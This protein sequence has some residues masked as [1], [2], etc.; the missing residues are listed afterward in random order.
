MGI[1]KVIAFTRKLLTKKISKTKNGWSRNG[2]NKIERSL[3]HKEM[4]HTNCLSMGDCVLFVYLLAYSQMN[5][6]RWMYVRCTRN[7]SKVNTRTFAGRSLRHCRYFIWLVMH[8]RA[9]AHLSTH[10]TNVLIS[11]SIHLFD[12]YLY[13]IHCR[14]EISHTL[15]LLKLN[16]F[17]FYFIHLLVLLLFS[18]NSAYGFGRKS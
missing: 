5:L 2:P 12:S 14:S 16:S 13:G 18:S 3:V 10:H 7:Y 9:R 8:S 17:Y 11:F 6:N 4:M 15:R 1:R